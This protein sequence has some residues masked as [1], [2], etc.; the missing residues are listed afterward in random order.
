MWDLTLHLLWHACLMACCQQASAVCKLLVALTRCLF[1]A[2][3]VDEWDLC[4]AC[5]T[6]A[7]GLHGVPVALIQLLYGARD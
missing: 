2:L 5:S 7:W 4:N 1:N 6:L 3:E